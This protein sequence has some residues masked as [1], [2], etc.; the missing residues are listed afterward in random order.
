MRGSEKAGRALL[1]SGSLGMGHDVMAEACAGSLE[2]RGWSTATMDSLK[3]MG[4][5]AGGL[6][7]RTFRTLLA[8]PGMYDAFHFEQLR[9]GGRLARLAEA[10]SSRYAVPTLRAELE[11]RPVDLLVSVFATGAAAAGRIKADHPAMT[12]AVFCTD[13]CPHRLWVHEST[14]LYLVTSETARR[15]VRR[16]HPRAEAVVVPTPVRAQFY[17]APT[18]REARRELGI[19]DDAPCVLLMAGSWGMGPLVDI[20]ETLAAAGIHTLVVAGRNASV[21]AALE[22]ARIR[23]PLLVPFGFTDRI[24]TLMAACDLVITTSGDTCSEARVIGR[25]LLLLD[26]VPGH[27]RENLQHELER[28]NADV[29]SLDP[30]GLRRSVLACL[31][32]VSP[33][34]VRVTQTPQAWESAF[35]AAL[36]RVGLANETVVLPS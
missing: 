15:F 2:Q 13:V 8:I 29:A 14:D 4:D 30:D 34:A 16:F 1:L 17:A 36:A 5:A 27:G 6:G 28:G 21:Q 26:V 33:A 32:D 9:P 22:A 11:R 18:Q 10:G 19:P 20:A 7:E 35:D 23:S 31:D 24:P 25:H 3:L 12:T